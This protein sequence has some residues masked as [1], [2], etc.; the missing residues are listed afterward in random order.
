[1][2]SPEVLNG[3]SEVYAQCEF[4]AQGANQEQGR[5]CRNESLFE[6][7]LV[8]DY[9]HLPSGDVPLVWAEEASEFGH[10][11]SADPN[12]LVMHHG[13]AVQAPLWVVQ[14]VIGE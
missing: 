11:F 14:Q 5:P 3:A 2:Q 6:Q 12:C 9:C 8:H 7:R 13:A 10:E 1:M 4:A